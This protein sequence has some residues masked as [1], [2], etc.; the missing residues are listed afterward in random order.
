MK[1]FLTIHKT[2]FLPYVTLKFH[3]YSHTHS[4]TSIVICCLSI[5]LSVQHP[6]LLFDSFT[7]FPFLFLYFIFIVKQIF[8]NKFACLSSSACIYIRLQN[9]YSHWTFILW[10]ILSACES[11]LFLV[12]PHTPTYMALSASHFF[13]VEYN[14]LT[15]VNI[16]SSVQSI[17]R[18]I[19]RLLCTFFLPWHSFLFV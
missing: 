14:T 3:S 7:D 9:I 4:N 2:H 17:N 10:I 19:F 6:F 11:S 5:Y 16:L 8:L 12:P 15:M 18:W 1:H 13:F